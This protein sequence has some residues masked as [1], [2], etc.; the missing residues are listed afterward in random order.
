MPLD[1]TDCALFVR[2]AATRNLSAAGR[3]FGLSPAASS[4]RIAQLE[5]QLGARLFNRTTR[6]I[7]LSEQGELFLQPALD[8]LQA[9]D[10]AQSALGGEQAQGLLRVA[11]SASFGRQHISPLIAPFLK[12]YPKIKLD[13]RLSDQVADLVQEGIDV[14]IRLGNLKDSSLVARKLA[15]NRRLMCAS[16]AYLAQYGTPAM[17]QELAQHQ[18]LVLGDKRI[19]Q[20]RQ[21]ANPEQVISVKVSGPLVSDNYEILSDAALHGVGFLKKA[22]WDAAPHLQ[23]GRLIALFPD[24]P[25]ADESFIWAVYASRQF[26]PKKT[27]VFIDYLAQ[28]F[29]E[30]PYWDED[31]PACCAAL[32]LQA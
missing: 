24:Y 6:S 2:V 20:F 29:G 18:V 27:Q 12:L 5:K 31:L 22:T 17:P 21:R 13:L 28:H 25:F 32:K 30:Q 26:L 7:T 4:A 23:A 15:P 11:M 10:H 14:A 1:L 3:D 16:P 19:L 8:L 9:A